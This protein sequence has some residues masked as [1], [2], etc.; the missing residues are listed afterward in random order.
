MLKYRDRIYFTQLFVK[1]CQ[2]SQSKMYGFGREAIWAKVPKRQ[3]RK[4]TSTVHN[5]YSGRSL[6]C[7]KRSTDMLGPG[8]GEHS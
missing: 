8:R 5:V 1:N 6:L 7:D 3:A 2:D 4:A